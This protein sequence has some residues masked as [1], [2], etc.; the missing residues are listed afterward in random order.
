MIPLSFQ[1]DVVHWLF[2]C[3]YKLQLQTLFTR[4]TCLYTQLHS[5]IM[6]KSANQFRLEKIIP[7]IFYLLF[8][9]LIPNGFTYYMCIPKQP[10][11]ILNVTTYWRCHIYI[12]IVFA[13]GV[14]RLVKLIFLNLIWTVAFKRISSLQVAQNSKHTVTLSSG[15]SFILEYKTVLYT[16]QS[17][18]SQETNQLFLFIYWANLI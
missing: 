13:L 8:Y 6:P 18:Y 2:K 7:K 17:V 10:R 14:P 4:T 9:S 15:N 3:T 16:W 12:M 1:G 11:N 5:G